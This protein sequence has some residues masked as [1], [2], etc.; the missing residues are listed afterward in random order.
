VTRNRGDSSAREAYAVGSG[1]ADGRVISRKAAWDA[2]G[3]G[4]SMVAA[5]HRQRGLVGRHVSGG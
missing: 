3:R 4:A 1:A 5:R 2:G